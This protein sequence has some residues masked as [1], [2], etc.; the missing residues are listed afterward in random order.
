MRALFLC[1]AVFLA[2]PASAQDD[3]ALRHGQAA[4]RCYEQATGAE[5]LAACSGL[6]TAACLASDPQN[7]AVA[8]RTACTLAEALFWDERLEI[9]FRQTRLALRAADDDDRASIP[10]A[11]IREERLRAAQRAW[12]AFQ[13]E[14][15]D[16]R[17]ALAATEQHGS[18]LA[19]E[20]L[21]EGTLERIGD[22]I[23]I[24][25]MVE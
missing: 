25:R 20:C 15:C 14:E 6:L 17:Q 10:E 2:T 23:D 19:T 8:F 11:A 4:Q 1:A 16:L 22:L 13:N 24:R 5:T 3:L 9:E 12:I 18:L 7:T 21:A